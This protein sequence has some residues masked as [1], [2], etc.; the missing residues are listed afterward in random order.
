MLFILHELCFNRFTILILLIH[1]NFDVQ[2]FKVAQ[3]T[4]LYTL[5][6]D[7]NDSSNDFNKLQNE[8]INCSDEWNNGVIDNWTK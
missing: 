6:Y 1:T 2:I 4:L 5:I 3:C 7:L 8:L